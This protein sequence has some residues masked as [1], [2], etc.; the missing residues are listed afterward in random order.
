MDVFESALDRQQ[1]CGVISVVM[2]NSRRI[3]FPKPL[4]EIDLPYYFVEVTS[5]E[6][7]SADH[8]LAIFSSALLRCP[9]SEIRKYVRV[10]SE[11]GTYRPTIPKATCEKY[12]L[13]PGE[14][15]WIVHWGTCLELWPEAAW[16]KAQQKAFDNFADDLKRND[17]CN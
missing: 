6:R 10:L 4:H 11:H 12:S 16:I 9:D 14:R 8:G 17:R 5:C 15:L 2:S 1:H 3:T 7:I 13:Y